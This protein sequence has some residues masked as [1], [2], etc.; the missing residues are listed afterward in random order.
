MTWNKKKPCNIPSTAL[1]HVTGLGCPGSFNVESRR[2]KLM[3][4]I[5][6]E[7]M[8]VRLPGIPVET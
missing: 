1:G 7:A 2:K 8:G 3:K 6:R 5:C 4:E